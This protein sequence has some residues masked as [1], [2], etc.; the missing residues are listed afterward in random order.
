MTSF[1]K[2]G[3]CGLDPAEGHAFIG[4][5]RY[6]HGDD[7]TWLEAVRTGIRITSPASTCF[8]RAQWAVIQCPN[9]GN[10][11]TMIVLPG[12]GKETGA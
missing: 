8:Q 9:M 5:T 1:T 2:C 3:L 11:P 4:N 12:F 6:C 7:K 10:Q